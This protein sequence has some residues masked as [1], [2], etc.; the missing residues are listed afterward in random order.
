MRTAFQ[1]LIVTVFALTGSSGFAQNCFTFTQTSSTPYQIVVTNAS[2]EGE[3][4]TAGDEIGVFDSDL[5]VGATEF[6]G[7]FNVSV[8][9][10]AIDPDSNLPGFIPGQPMSFKLCDDSAG[11]IEYLA[12]PIFAQGNGNF[13][14]GTFAVVMLVVPESDGLIGD[15]NG[16]SQI[17]D[18]DLLLLKLHILGSITLSPDQAYRA[19]LDQNHHLDIRDILALQDM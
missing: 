2:I 7:T 12:Y 5:C 9:A 4:L 18:H 1:L 13:G 16:D 6:D 14:D 19:D 15:I 17:T 3:P 11:N 10:N 8:A